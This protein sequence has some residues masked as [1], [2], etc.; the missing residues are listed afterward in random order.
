MRKDRA[1]ILWRGLRGLCPRCGLGKIFNRGV[2][3]VE[4]CAECG[5]PIQSKEGDCWVFVYAT[6][7][8]LIGL[9]IALMLLFFNPLAKAVGMVPAQIVF[10]AASI[11]VVVLSLPPRKGLAL[12]IDYLLGSAK[13]PAP[14]K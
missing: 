12:A 9:I 5:L 11:V 10:L 3:F 14:S 13:V 6:M 7:A 8:G 2:F 4:N 1:K